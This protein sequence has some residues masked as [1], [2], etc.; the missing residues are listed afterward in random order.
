MKASTAHSGPSEEEADSQVGD[1]KNTLLRAETKNRTNSLRTRLNIVTG[2]SSE[3]YAR[4]SEESVT[5]LAA[6]TAAAPTADKYAHG[7]EIWQ[8][9]LFQRDSASTAATGVLV[10]DARPNS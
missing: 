1:S 10:T 8:R 9:R 7:L 3:A 2:R 5:A 6:V 4:R